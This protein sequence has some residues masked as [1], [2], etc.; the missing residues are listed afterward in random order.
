LNVIASACWRWSGIFGQV[1]PNRKSATAHRYQHY[2][3]PIRVVPS[4]VAAGIIECV[5]P[6]TIA[7]SDTQITR[8]RIDLDR[9]YA[10]TVEMLQS[11]REH[12]Y[13]RWQFELLAVI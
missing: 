8:L 10:R 13:G 9:L 5:D 1:S 7:E 11:L 3:C 2:T 4:F 6:R 12:V